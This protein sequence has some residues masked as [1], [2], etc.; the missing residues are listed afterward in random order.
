MS[1]SQDLIYMAS[2]GKTK[3]PKHIGLSITCHKMTQ[4]KEIIQLLNRNGQGISYDEIQGIDTTWATQQIN[5]NNIVLPSNMVLNTFTHAAADNWNRAT[6][7]VTGEHLDIVNLVMFQSNER[8]IELGSFN[9]STNT[10]RAPLPKE[11]KRSLAADQLTTQIFNC[12]NLQGNNIG[13]LHLK[14]RLNLDWYFVDSLS[15]S[16]TRDIDR[17]WIFLRICP[18]TIF[19]IQLENRAEQPVPGWSAFHAKISNRPGIPTNIGYCQPIPAPPAEFNT[20]YTVL[21]RAE[22]LFRRIGQQAVILTWDEA[23]Y[24]KAQIVKWRNATEFENLFNRMGGFHR[25]LNYMGDIGKIMEGSGFED[26]L[27]EAGV[28]S[29]AVISKIMAGKAYNRGIRAHKLLFEAL[30]RL[31]WKAF[32]S[33][34]EENDIH[35]D[36]EHRELLLGALTIVHNLMADASENKENL[37]TALNELTV[38]LH[39]IIELIR[40]FEETCIKHSDT[41][42]F[43]EN[44]LQM[45][46]LLLA[47]IAS[48][49]NGDIKGHINTFSNMLAYDFACNH[50]NYAR[51]GSVYI[52]EMHLL[53]ELHPEIFEEFLNGKHIINRSLQEEKYFSGVW[54]DMAIEQSINRDC[55]S[56]GGLTGLKTNRAAMERWFLTAHLKANVATA[57]KAMLGLGIKQ[58][59]A[60]H[61][62]A[63]TSRVGRD[64]SAVN[65]ICEVIEERMSNP[66]TV[67]PEWDSNNPKPL[68][69]IA[70]GLVASAEI[71]SWLKSCKPIGSQKL[72]NFLQERVHNQIKDFFDPIEKTKV[73]SFSSKHE[74]GTAKKGGK[75]VA[76]EID[77][78]IM[79][80]LVV[81]SQT[82]DI[83]LATLFAH[84]LSAVPLSLF[85]PD[86][87][88][89]KC[90]KS[91]L[92]K[93]IERDFAIE[94]LEDNEKSTLTVIDFMVLVRMICTETSKCKTFGEL[95]DALLKAVMG[96]FK[97]GDNVD[98]VC[99]RYNIKDSIKG[100]ERARRGQVRMQEIKI[101]SEHTPLP[102]QRSKLLS[103]PKNKENICNFVFD[104]WTV[105]AA[106]QLKEGQSLV[107]SGG[108]EEGLTAIRVTCQGKIAIDALRSD[109]EEADS[110][111]F[112]HIAYA[113]ETYVPERIIVWSID[114]DVAAICP[115]VI[116]LLNIGEL[117]FKTGVKNKKRF[118]PMHKICSE[119]GHDMSLVLPV[120]HALTGC[121]STSA[122]SGI[123][124]K[125]VMAAL[126]ND[127]GLVTEILNSVGV[128][129]GNV[130][131]D[132]VKACVKLVSY[133]YMGKGTYTSTTKMRKDLFTKKQLVSERLPPTEP[134]LKEHIKRA[135]YQGYIWQC[136]TKSML[137][138]PSADG[139]GWSKNEDD[140]LVPTKN[141]MPAAPEGLDELTTC[142]CKSGCKNN[143]CACRRKELLCCDGCYCEEDCENRD[144]YA[145]ESDQDDE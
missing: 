139:N 101:L 6:D 81:V 140:E 72:K 109:H 2:R 70:T 51:W 119:I 78:H 16:A 97:Y 26:C 84:E 96:M 71:C 21:K 25:A 145:M 131:E 9:N 63:T 28:Y 102:K 130:N 30:S 8:N 69:N 132:G 116:L 99:D 74:K 47:Y 57:T 13:P 90:C 38:A 134:E 1:I 114:T 64:E 100:S 123:G 7:S 127:E 107:L 110:R 117:F 88:M 67:E 15:H 49:R 40:T 56:L 46:K 4:S 126:R 141:I 93:E 14:N 135:N 39:P 111:M 62:E 94:N 48:E 52:A 42:A 54:S 35:I 80:R 89:R 133:L 10:H 37:S 58:Q 120:I 144:Q 82:R 43:W 138:L 36:D 33:W 128:D 76:M 112:S 106:T 86:G 44:Y 23:L 121:D 27:I 105:K 92:L 87:T 53:E 98:V 31:K 50:L 60:P 122:F 18:P 65:E 17:A 12:P 103:N 129:P 125:S 3:T 24:S 85:N 137:E 79:S 32:I 83:D 19:E 34:A 73:M 20:V 91:D 113:M 136:A 5:Q 108:Y 61:K 41:F 104:Q 142:K 11:R 95:S 77:R 143:R 22:A 66:F 118:I 59:S 124:K 29:G 68:Y 45:V 115:R 55:G 75:L